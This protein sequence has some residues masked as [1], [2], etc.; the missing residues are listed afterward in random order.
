MTFWFTCIIYLLYK[1]AI[2]S[3]MPQILQGV[4]K[5]YESKLYNIE[6]KLCKTIKHKE[7]LSSYKK[8]KKYPKGMKL[9]FNLEKNSRICPLTNSAV[10]GKIH[11]NS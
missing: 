8:S 11:A 4:L 1:V 2:V 9:K 3:T 5:Q 7:L 6:K 10:R